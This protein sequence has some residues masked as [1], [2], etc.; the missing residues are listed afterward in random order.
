[1]LSPGKPQHEHKIAETGPAA[2][3]DEPVELL[4]VDD[5]QENLLA[6]EAVLGSSGYCLIQVRSGDEALRYLLD[7]EPALI[8]MDVQMPGIDG[9]ETATIIKGSERTREIPII[10]IT[11]LGPDEHFAQRGYEHGAVD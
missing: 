5:R 4:L 11:A 6:L 3:A 1:M 9:Y 7:H 2:W 10:F 8:L